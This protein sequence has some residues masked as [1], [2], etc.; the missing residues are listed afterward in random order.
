MVGRLFSIAKKKLVTV[1]TKPRNVFF[2]CQK[3]RFCW[4]NTTNNER[5]HKFP[6]TYHLSSFYKKTKNDKKTVQV[7]TFTFSAKNENYVK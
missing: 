6:F 2:F 1:V 5:S 4:F 3:I 7:D